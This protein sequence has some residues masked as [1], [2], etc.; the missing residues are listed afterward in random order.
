MY[1]KKCLTDH[2][3]NWLIGQPPLQGWM[4][5]KHTWR[6]KERTEDK[7]V[8]AFDFHDWLHGVQL[9]LLVARLCPSHDADS[10]C[11]VI[12]RFRYYVVCNKFLLFFFF[13]YTFSHDKRTTIWIDD[14]RFIKCDPNQLNYFLKIFLH[15]SLKK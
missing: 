9:Y 15:I 5:L 8:K 1:G 2:H 3:F 13:F 6:N 11:K 12:M 7:G 10:C 14:L 4:Y